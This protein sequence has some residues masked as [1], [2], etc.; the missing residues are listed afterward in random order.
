MKSPAFAIALYSATLFAP[1]TGLADDKPPTIEQLWQIIQAQQKEIEELKRQQETT[2]EKVEATGAALDTL[3]APVSQT[4]G[5]DASALGSGH[6]P[7]EHGKAGK[8]VVGGYG[9]LHYNNLDSGN[10]IDFHRAI[11]YL[12]HEFTDSIRFFS[13]IEYEHAD[14]SKNGAVELEQAWLEFDL[15]ENHSAR[16]GLFLVPAGILNETH[17]PATFYGVERNPVEKNIIPTTWWVGGAGLRGELAPGWS[18]D[19]ALH[20]G[21]KT[22][23]GDNYAVRKGRQK[24]SEAAADDLAATGRL[25]WTG[26]AGVELSTTLQ[27]QSDITQGLD[28]AAGD[29]W[30]FETHADIERGPFGLRALYA[31]WDLSGNGPASVG[32]DEQEGFYIEPSYSFNDKVG[33][34]ARYNQ[35]DNRAGDSSDRASKTTVASTSVSAISSSPSWPDTVQQGCGCAPAALLSPVNPGIHRNAMLK[36]FILALVLAAYCTVSPARGTYQEPADFLS[37][38]S[39]PGL[40]IRYWSR[41]KRS[42]WILDE[43]GKEKPITVGLVVNDRGLERVR[44]LAFRESRG[45]EVRHPFFT[46][47]FKGIGLTAGRRLDR[48]IDGISGATLSVRALEKLARLALC[49]HDRVDSND[50]SQSQN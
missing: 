3:A 4:T 45:W 27:Y 6:G 46:D 30:L 8:T 34:F 50:D 25:K 5:E 2:D 28:S 18:Y 33:V 44:V 9:E 40:R 35:W 1:L 19:I 39:Y 13:E 32:A 47:Q 7:F 41:D 36:H 48:D 31:R 49:L 14:T 26:M 43:I 15:N 23:M 42:A 16:A 38:T 11:L 17:E 10:E 29:A 12:G 22:S 24:T 20:E 37:E 21:L